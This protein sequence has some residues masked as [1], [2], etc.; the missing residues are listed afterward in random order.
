[1][2]INRDKLAKI[3]TLLMII[4][5]MGYSYLNNNIRALINVIL[6]TFLFVLLAFSSHKTKKE[7][8]RV[9]PWVIL[10]L[11]LYIFRNHDIK[12]GNYGRFLYFFSAFFFMMSI[13]VSSKWLLKFSN[14]M[15]IIAILESFYAVI[16]YINGEIMNDG[17]ILIAFVVT[18][19]LCLP[20][21]FYRKNRVFNVLLILL[22]IVLVFISKKR[23]PF[24]FLSLSLMVCIFY[25]IKVESK[26]TGKLINLIFVTAT[27]LVIIYAISNLDAILSIA[28]DNDFT[29]GRTVLYR[30][31]IGLFKKYP[32]FG[33]GW[34]GYRSIEQIHVGESYY[35]VHN[36]YLQLG[37]EVGIVGLL[38]FCAFFARCFFLTLKTIKNE[39]DITKKKFLYFSMFCQ[40]F[41]LLYGITGNPLYDFWLY[42]YG[43]SV[44]ALL[45]LVNEKSNRNLNGYNLERIE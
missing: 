35:D 15:I 18:I 26:R 44:G 16:K 43:I 42:F 31:A 39:R 11:F 22:E 34:G 36:I 33:S 24:L 14:L 32:F 23:G 8:K 25:Y 19:G 4:S 20:N 38:I 2:L 3:S 5:M 6:I 37:C 41:F 7:M 21:V 17:N 27:M 29:T 10:I 40:T 30:R 12:G 45:S 28:Q 13:S 9:L 1:M